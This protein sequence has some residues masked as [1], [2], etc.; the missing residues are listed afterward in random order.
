MNSNTTDVSLYT[1]DV[2]K[3]NGELAKKF[4]TS[5]PADTIHQLIENFLRQESESK[6]YL[7]LSDRLAKVE[8]QL[9]V[10]KSRFVKPTPT[11]VLDIYGIKKDKNIDHMIVACNRK[12]AEAKRTGN[13]VMAVLLS[14]ELSSLIDQRE[15]NEK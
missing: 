13:Q 15:E 7:L 12:I 8:E 1:D 6:E 9:K 10:E 2:E 3:I 14:N 5:T 4:S 11:D